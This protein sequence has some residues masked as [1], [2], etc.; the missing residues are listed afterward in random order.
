VARQGALSSASRG[1]ACAA[2]GALCAARR[3]LTSRPC[4]LPA[5]PPS[6]AQDPVFSL[7]FNPATGHLATCG[8]DREIKARRARARRRSARRPAL[9]AQLSPCLS[10]AFLAR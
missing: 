8:A 7:D 5:P 2:Q 1:A 9:A 3:A 10:R 6:R 4:L